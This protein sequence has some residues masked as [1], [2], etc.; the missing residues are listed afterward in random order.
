M[1]R[2]S[3]LKA[4]AATGALLASRTAARAADMSLTFPEGFTW[5]VSTSS[6]QIEGATDADG[7][8][9]SVWDTFSRIP[10]KIITGETGDPA[11]DH[12]NRY[13]EDV[14]LMAQAGMKAYRFSTA[15][16]RILPTGQG[17]ANTKGLDFYDRLVDALLRQGIEPWLCLYHWDLPQ[18]L[19]DKGGWA[20]RDIAHW[21]TDY[22]LV[23]A[24]RLGDRVKHWTMLNEPSVVAIFGHG[25]GTHAPGLTGKD[26]YL[27]A[28][29]HQNLAQ[30]AALKALR[31]AGGTDWKLGT[32]LSVQPCKP[33]GGLEANRQAAVVWD[34]VW[35]RA[36]MDPLFHGRY[37]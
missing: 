8:G 22:A 13:L 14:A 17:A 9:P 31:A 21:F 30:G 36:C 28:I 7:R 16:P 35:N 18:A 26:N 2:R 27:K 20:N 34:A 15:W 10:G 29:H 19:Q 4:T 32:V 33:E 1:K 11:C 12:Y 5:G 25:F 3:F 23:V 37:P 24:G 6:Y